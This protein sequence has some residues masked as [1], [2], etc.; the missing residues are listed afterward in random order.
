MMARAGFP[1]MTTYLKVCKH[2]KNENDLSTSLLFQVGYTS[3]QCYIPAAVSVKLSLL[4]LYRRIF[5]TQ[6]S[7]L[8]SEVV[9]I[10]VS[11]WGI[12]YVF[13]NLFMCHP[14]EK[15][16]DPTIPGFCFQDGKVKLL[17]GLS[18]EIGLDCT[19]LVLPIKMVYGLQMN[20]A[21]KV[22][23]A[24]IFLL[25]A[26]YVLRLPRLSTGANPRPTRAIITNIVRCILPYDPETGG[27]TYLRSSKPQTRGPF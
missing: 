7:R 17:V 1:D 5:P 27:R 9:M 18:V 13:V 16:W 3:V 21:K 11:Y 2:F 6:S 15:L 22:S 26:L 8:A 24:M 19:I 4:C 12:S 20:R 14:T 10:P 23:V 25:G